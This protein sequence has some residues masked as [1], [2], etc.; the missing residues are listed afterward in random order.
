MVLSHLWEQAGAV[1]WCW[2]RACAGLLFWNLCTPAGTSAAGDE[3][4]LGSC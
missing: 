3:G 4:R 2:A 1:G